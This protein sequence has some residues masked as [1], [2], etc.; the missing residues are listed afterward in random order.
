MVH[1]LNIQAVVVQAILL[2]FLLFETITLQGQVLNDVCKFATP[3]P[4]AINYCSGEAAFTNVGA[5]ADPKFDAATN[6]CLSLLWT[7]G[8]WFSFVP[9][10]PA[11]LIR[12]FGSGNNNNTIRSPKILL[13][14]ECNEFLFCSPGKD[15]GF[16]EL[17]FDDLTINHTYYIMIES[18]LDGAGSFKLC[19]DEFSPVRSPE[20]DCDRA[21]VLCDKSSFVVPRL[22]GNGND[23]NEVSP[24][25]CIGGEFASAWYKWTCDEPGRLTFVLTPN[26]NDRGQITDDL[27]FAL[28][29]LPGGL[30][31][32]DNKVLLRCEGAGANTQNG[33][34]L[35][36]SQWAACNG[37]TGLREGE[38]DVS[39]PGGCLGNNNNY[40]SPIT[41]EK[42]KSYVLIINNFSRSG[43][44][45]GIEFG[46]NGTFLG[47][48]PDLEAN[49]NKAFECDKSVQ[50]VNKSISETDPIVSYK[51]NFGEKAEPLRADGF[52]PF[53][54]LYTSFGDKKA[55]ITVETSRGC[56]VTKIVDLF[57][58]ACCKDT[59]TLNVDA[60]VQDVICFNTNTGQILA[61]GFSGAPEY[62][63]SLNDQA[64]R[65]NPLYANLTDGTYKLKIQDT[66]GCVD[67]II[68]T[69]V[70][71]PPILVDAGPD[72]IIELSD[73]AI[74]DLVYTPIKDRDDIQWNPAFLR[75]EDLEYV[76]RPF[77]TT[78][79]IVTV[80]DSSGCVGMDTVEIRVV[81]N[82]QFHPP[83]VISPN[84]D[85]INDFFNVWAVKGADRVLSLEVYDRWGNLVFVGEDGVD[86]TRSTVSSGWD[87]KFYK[88]CDKN[89]SRCGQYVEQGVYA[90]HAKVLWLD[91]SIGNFA[92][93][94][95]VIRNGEE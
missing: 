24:G 52:G 22:E 55:A 48:K 95:T 19:V 78:T 59:S 62:Q 88:N 51:W 21:V 30:D 5:T 39:E 72:Q 15:A 29:E 75:N 47:P 43:L 81:K 7:N 94:V 3:L 85:G 18:S 80:I 25:I 64:F 49:A 45:F 17:V 71:P 70:Q 9:T 56:R 14:E 92:G 93:D 79:Y 6:S 86:F 28:Y 36:L 35:P 61:E 53:D 4:S 63:F 10:K 90:W 77:N 2:W 58:D 65:K 37:P 27:D 87:G 68:K 50:F 33:N 41:M 73:E 67:S 20:S 83:N 40:V 60:L 46:G 8:V 82:L 91:G 32:C 23:Q 76:V 84:G 38:V 31:D 42:G 1:R 57:V 12:V 16:D 11:V 66:K 74:I 89:N 69:I 34:I 44:G 54:V 13:F 26:N